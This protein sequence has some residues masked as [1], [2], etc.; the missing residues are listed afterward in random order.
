MI[1][2]EKFEKIISKEDKIIGDI[3]YSEAFSNKL[4]IVI[5]THG[6]TGHKD[7][8]FLPYFAEEL[9][10]EG[11]VTIVYNFST[12]CVDPTRDIFV[13]I[14]K[15][16]T[17]TISK[18]VEEL[19]LLVDSIQNKSIF[20]QKLNQIVDTSKIYLIGQSLGGAVTIIYS[21]KYNV[22]EKIIL[23]GTVGTLFRYTKRQISEWKKKGI[24]HFTNTRTGQELKINY[25]YYKDLLENN[26]FLENFLEKIQVPTLFIH[27]TEDLTVP[28]SEI[29]ELIKKAKNP[30]V[31]LKL[32]EKTGH[33]FGIEHPFTRPTS[34]LQ[35]VIALAKNFLKQ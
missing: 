30:F 8:G 11:F 6:F 34:A 12:D 21:A 7:W 14:E 9:A 16:A 4:P 17:F 10:N 18:E 15:F 25:S 3:R 24:W 23:L 5:V 26:F 32:I 2:I 28:K 31:E 27:G 20:S 19:K 33:T 29:E 22:T 13:D 1:K 35:T